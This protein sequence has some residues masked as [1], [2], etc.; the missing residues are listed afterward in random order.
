MPIPQWFTQPIPRRAPAGGCTDPLN[1]RAYRGGEVLPFYVPRPIMPQLDEAAYPGFLALCE[2]RGVTV[3]RVTVNPATLRNHQRIDRIHAA[4]M[5]DEVRAKPI[6][7]SADGFILDGNHRWALH[8]QLGL[9]VACYRIGL[10]FEQAVALLFSDPDT[11]DLAD[12][13]QGN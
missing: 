9:P 5:P 12:K 3:E 13:P 2:A 4:A 11:Y 8:R 7:T 6:L 10:P 1:G